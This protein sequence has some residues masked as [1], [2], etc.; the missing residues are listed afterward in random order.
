M[1][2]KVETMTYAGDVPWHQQDTPCNPRLA[3]S[4]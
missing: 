2:A 4:S 1:P 3:P